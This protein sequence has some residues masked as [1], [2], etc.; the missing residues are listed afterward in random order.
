MEHLARTFGEWAQAPDWSWCARFAYQVIE[1]R[2]TGGGNFRRLYAR[3]L[4]EARPAP[5]RGLSALSARMAAIA[6]G[7]PAAM[8]LKR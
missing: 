1:R 6:D 3:F 7:G 4:S 5:G 2:G 8:H